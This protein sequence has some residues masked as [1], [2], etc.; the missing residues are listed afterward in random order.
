MNIKIILICSK[1]VSM[2]SLTAATEQ[3]STLSLP[4]EPPW[5]V[6]ISPDTEHQTSS[7]HSFTIC[8]FLRPE[9][10]SLSQDIWILHIK[11][12]ITFYTSKKY[13]S[14]ECS[15][16]IWWTDWLDVLFLV[17]MVTELTD[18]PLSEVFRRGSVSGFS[19]SQYLLKGSLIQQ[20]SNLLIGCRMRTTAPLVDIIPIIVEHSKRF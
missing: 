14:F 8:T 13:W 20:N 17:V 5:G 19:P 4:R 12:N 10:S 1:I 3:I 2:I 9:Y 18:R 11:E 6:T 15:N 16:C 7:L